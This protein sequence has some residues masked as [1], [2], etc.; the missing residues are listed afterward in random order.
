MF[1][2]KNN[3]FWR[4]ITGVIRDIHNMDSIHL[5]LVAKQCEVSKKK[6]S[7]GLRTYRL[8]RMLK[9]LNQRI[10]SGKFSKEEYYEK[11]SMVYRGEY[12]FY[13]DID[14]TELQDYY[15]QMSSNYWGLDPPKGLKW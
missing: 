5:C 3:D 13:P 12:V 10:E 11:I 4:D 9:E 14:N 15:A 6:G 7:I 8:P 1:N 2:N